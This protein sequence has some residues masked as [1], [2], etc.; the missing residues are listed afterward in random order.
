MDYTAI[1]KRICAKRKQKD[2][3]QEEFAEKALPHNTTHGKRAI[4]E[5]GTN[6]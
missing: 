4:I 5:L 2:L 1:G 3:S 6:K